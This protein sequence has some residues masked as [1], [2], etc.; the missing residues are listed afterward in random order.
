MAGTGKRLL[1]L[2]R[3]DFLPRELDNRKPGP[4]F[5]D[6]RYI[7]HDTWYRADGK[8]FQPRVRYFAGRATTMCGATL[9]RLRRGINDLYLAGERREWLL[10]NVQLLGKSN[11]P[12]WLTT[13]GTPL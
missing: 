1:L 4:V 7:S 11:S 13:M 12:A 3:G 10:G 2:Q 9:Y 5:G 8:S 6:G